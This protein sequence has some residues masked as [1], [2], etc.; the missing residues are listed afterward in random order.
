MKTR[1]FLIVMVTIFCWS[2]QSELEYDKDSIFGKWEI[3]KFAYSDKGQKISN[4]TLIQNEVKYYMVPYIDVG[5]THGSLEGNLEF[6]TTAISW[7][8]GCYYYSIDGSSMNCLESRYPSYVY[9]KFRETETWKDIDHAL[10]NT[11]SYAIQGNEL[12]IYFT[13]LND[14]NLL[15]LKKMQQ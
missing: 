6:S 3:M 13:G 4:E 14:K 7:A 8:Y 15:I 11:K 10:S 12:R 9:L 1:E 2:C 5:Q